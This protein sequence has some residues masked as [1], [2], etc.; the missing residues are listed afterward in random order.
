MTDASDPGGRVKRKRVS[1]YG[2]RVLISI[3]MDP[4]LHA[5]LQEFCQQTS[6]PATTY[7]NK[8]IANDLKRWQA[9]QK[10][11]EEP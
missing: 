7:I 8:L 6:Q 1:I 3:R 5:A 10:L 9:K 4:K 11:A 2:D